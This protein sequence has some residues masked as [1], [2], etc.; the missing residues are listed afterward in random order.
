MLPFFIKALYELVDT[1]VIV[2]FI[3]FLQ[4][5]VYGYNS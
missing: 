3:H 2:S 4:V 1:R 5:K